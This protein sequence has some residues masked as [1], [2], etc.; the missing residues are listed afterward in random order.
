MVWQV[1]SI[2]T[3][4]E[5][6][7]QPGSETD[8]SLYER[9]CAAIDG[10]EVTL[11]F[12]LRRLRQGDSPVAIQADG[13][14]WFLP[15]AL[16][17]VG[18]WLAVGKYTDIPSWE[19]GVPLLV[20]AVVIHL[21]VARRYVERRLEKRVAVFAR[22]DVASWRRLWKFGGVMLERGGATPARCAAPDGNWFEFARRLEP[23]S[24]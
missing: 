15:S 17:V 12:D 18:G 21:T 24:G 3:T 6:P 7:P 16:A 22:K 4:P 8:A 23:K 13:N 2:P 10:G 19:V 1:S 20:A 9:L 14:V 5:P 11:A